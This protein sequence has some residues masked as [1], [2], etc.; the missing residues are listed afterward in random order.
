MEIGGV[1]GVRLR[2]DEVRTEGEVCH[3]SRLVPHEL[4]CG[5]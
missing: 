2:L 3:V 4:Q 5:K 1:A